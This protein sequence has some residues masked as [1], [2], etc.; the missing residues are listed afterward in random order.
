[1]SGKRVQNDGRDPDLRAGLGVPAEFHD[2]PSHRAGWTVGLVR[3]AFPVLAKV[4]DWSVERLMRE[5]SKADIAWLER[6]V[7]EARTQ[8]VQLAAVTMGDKVIPP[9]VTLEAILRYEPHLS[10]QLS[11][12]L[13]KRTRPA[14]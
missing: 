12:V 3:K 6:R 7:L 13:D 11:Q 10:R 14:N 8:V 2:E 4:A 1:M 5:L 9:G